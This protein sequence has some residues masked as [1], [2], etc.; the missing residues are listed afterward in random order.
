MAVPIELVFY[1]PEEDDAN[2]AAKAVFERFRRLN[3]V[4]SDFDPNSD[5]SMLSQ[6]AGDGRA[7][8]VGPDLWAVLFRAQEVARQSDGAFDVTVG[9]AVRLWRRAR[10][11]KQLPSQERIDQALQLVGYERIRLDP[12]QRAVELTKPG[13]QID[14]GGIAKGYAIDEG[15]RVLRTLGITRAMIHAGGDI[16][17]A[18]P[19]PDKP[20]WTIGVGLLEPTARPAR[21]VSLSRCAVATSGDMW[22]FVVIAGKRYSHIVD[23][24]TGIGL[25]EHCSVTVIAPEAM[26]ADALSTAVSVLGP[27][28]GLRLVDQTPQAAAFI[29]RASPSKVEIYQSRR[30]QDLRE[31]PVEPG[32]TPKQPPS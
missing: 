8:P 31:A 15:L 26:T 30:W 10:R 11:Q 28:R 32:G 17:L 20:G 3:Q 22:Q 12:C 6:S 13:M 29:V 2:G 27:E 9:P 19:P 5:I 24:K 4:L 1:A 25:T 14:L 18:D 7:H 16:G 23:P 21:F